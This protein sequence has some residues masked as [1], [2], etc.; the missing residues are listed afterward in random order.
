M[1]WVARDGRKRT[2]KRAVVPTDP[3][4]PLFALLPPLWERL[5]TRPKLTRGRCV[6]LRVLCSALRPAVSWAQSGSAVFV[7]VMI[8]NSKGEV[9][10][11]TADSLTIT[12][13]NDLDKEYAITLPLFAAV[14]PEVCL[15]F[16][17]PSSLFPLPSSL[18]S[19]LSFD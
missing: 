14:K 19:L 16:S 18:F 2:A 4:S 10:T 1:R 7:K 13:H 17:L 12:A 15:F 9:V 6:A 8:D 3:S 5:G 11:I